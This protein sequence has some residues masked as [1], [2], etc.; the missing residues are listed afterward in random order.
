MIFFGYGHDRL[1]LHE[2]GQVP[3]MLRWA[4]AHSRQATWEC[5][6]PECHHHKEKVARHFITTPLG[7]SVHQQQ[8]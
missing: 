8:R 4:C 1:A 7:S 6:R 3:A 5:I 2:L